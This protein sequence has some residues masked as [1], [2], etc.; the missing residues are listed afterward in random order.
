MKSTRLCITGLLIACCMTSV[1][2]FGHSGHSHAAQRNWT[3]NNGKHFTASFVRLSNDDVQLRLDNDTLISIPKKDLSVEDQN[4]VQKRMEAIEQVNQ[5]FK[6]KPTRQPTNQHEMSLTADANSLVDGLMMPVPMLLVS[7]LNEAAYNESQ[8]ASDTRPAIAKPFEPF[9]SQNAIKTR[10]DD[11][12][13]YVESNGIPDHR[14][15]VGITSW[16]QQVPLPQQYTGD[17]AWRIPLNP[18]P[19]K[20]PLSTKNRFLRGAI[21]LAANGIPIF[22]PLN[23]RGD[24]AYLF[25]ELDEFGGHCGR[26]D[27]YHYHIAPVHLQKIVGPGLPI[28]YA[29]DGY[30]IYGYEEPDGSPVK[31]LDAFNGHTDQNGNYH[32]H[33]TKTYPYL[34]GGFHGEVTEREG[35]VDPQPRAEPVRPDLRPLRDAKIVEFEETSPKN[36]A[37]TYEVNGKKGTVRYAIATDGSVRFVFVDPSGKQSEKTFSPRRPAPGERR[38]PPPRNENRNENSNSG[39]SD[40]RTSINETKNPTTSQQSEFNAQQTLTVTSSAFTPDGNYPAEFTCDGA[41][42]SPPIQWSGAP[43]N[44]KFYAV[45]L[46]HIAPGNDTKSYWVLYNIPASTTEL[47]RDARDTVGT[48]GMNDKK[49]REYDPMCS[50]GP[51]VKKY[52]IT[53]YALSEKLNI[54]PEKA[55]RAELLKAIKDITVGQG[56]L[57]FQYERKR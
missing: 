6:R 47:P 14:M 51:G 49:K 38:P 28:A 23:N 3:Q 57:S 19:A 42:I 54:A 52:H 37:L 31:G 20:N 43:A 39:N 18:V 5:M 30:P 27:D 11:R 13:L 7:V 40:S 34:N 41:R 50:K 53:V 24:D 4:W 2:T 16:Q 1:A 36:Y 26:A 10:W 32:Y 25:G 15:M 12:F 33:A 44:T 46:W 35:Q 8:P 56:T 21:A 22:N 55:S 9:V 45:N 29:L 17:N 48:L